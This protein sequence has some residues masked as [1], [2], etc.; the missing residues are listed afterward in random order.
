MGKS[1]LI[2][3]SDNNKKLVEAAWKKEIESRVNA[4]SKGKIKTIS[5]KK[6]K[7]GNKL[8]SNF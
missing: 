2:N 6:I 7:K 1:E 4:F 3:K 5:Y 8:K